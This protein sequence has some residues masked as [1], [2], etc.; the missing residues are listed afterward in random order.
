MSTPEITKEINSFFLPILM[1]Y[2]QV[3]ACEIDFTSET[4]DAMQIL[5]RV[6][7]K[8]PYAADRPHFY[9]SYPAF[10]KKDW[11]K[12]FYNAS[13]MTS[14]RDELYKAINAYLR[15]ESVAEKSGFFLSPQL[16]E[17]VEALYSSQ[18]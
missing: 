5:Y 4:H 11:K 14:F 8:E 12:I 3:P 6:N 1:E 16:S 7:T 15:G 18:E 9:L 10:P 13:S 2:G 17:E